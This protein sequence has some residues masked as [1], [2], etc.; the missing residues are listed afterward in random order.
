[1]AVVAVRAAPEMISGARTMTGLLIVRR[2]TH[3]VQSHRASGRRDV[4]PAEGSEQLRL[5]ALIVGRR[6]TAWAELQA[7]GLLCLERDVA[8]DAH[9]PFARD[10]AT[11]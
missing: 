9:E 2:I 4:H 3:N 8:V 7:R 6:P 10:V 1:M 11:R 5:A